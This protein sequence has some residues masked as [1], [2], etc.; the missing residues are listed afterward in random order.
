MRM[1]THSDYASAHNAYLA[2][3]DYES[4]NSLSKAKAYR[5]A[6]VAMISFARSASQG[7]ANYQNDVGAWERQLDYVRD[8]VARNT[9]ATT[10]R[11]GTTV[12]SFSNFRRG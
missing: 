5:D 6:L 9:T 4:E 3:A 8:W 1:A 10:P 2:N 12:A 11:H 7:N